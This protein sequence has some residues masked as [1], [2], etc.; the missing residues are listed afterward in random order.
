LV[1]SYLLGFILMS[2]EYALNTLS[3][4]NTAI[5]YSMIGSFEEAKQVINL[6]WFFLYIVVYVFAVWDCYRRTIDINKVY[7]LAYKEAKSSNVKPIHFSTT[8]V[9]ILEKKIPWLALAWS[10]LM[11]G[12]G[13]IYLHKVGAFFFHLI[14]WMVILYYS[15]LLEGFYF[16]MIGDF[17]QV[18]RVLNPQW[19]LYLPSIYGFVMY[20]AYS[21]AIENN[22]LF[23][24]SQSRYLKKTYQVVGLGSFYH[25]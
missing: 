9:N 21:F 8:E 6:R 24:L 23:E 20:T 2:F 10:F 4:I 19:V 22:K 5:Y 12:L 25:E 7:Q 16:T 11:P 3:S 14:W 13:F 17:D 15:R 1:N 18:K